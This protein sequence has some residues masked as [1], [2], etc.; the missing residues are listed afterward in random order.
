MMSTATAVSDAGD[1]RRADALYRAQ[2]SL[3]HHRTDRLF[4]ALMAIQWFAGIAA[5]LWISPR[6]WS[7]AISEPHLHVWAAILLG[8]AITAL[9]VL[10]AWQRPGSVVTRHVIAIGQMLTSALLIHLTGGRIETHFHIFGS[11]AFLACY[12]DW[13]VLCTAT[14]VVAADHGLRGWLWPESVY[15]VIAGAPLRLIEHAGW[16]VF[17]D[18]F[19]IVTIRQS[20]ADMR[21]NADHQAQLESTNTRIEAEVARRTEELRQAMDDTARA[22]RQ[23]IEANKV[24]EEQNKE[25][26]QFTYVA[27]HDLQE[28]VRKLVSFSRLLEQDI[29]GDLNEDAK[30]DLQ[31]IVDA[32][33]RMRTLVQALLELS[34]VGRSAMK[35]DPVDLNH[36]VDDAL[37]ALELKIDETGAVIK[38]DRFP[39]VIGDQTM[40]TQLLQNLISNALKFTEEAAPEIRL[41]ATGDEDHWTLGVRDNGIGMKSEYAERIFQPFQRLHNRGEYEGTGIG[42]SICKKTVQRH[43]GQIWV[44]SDI[45]RGAHFR[46]T[47][48]VA[49]IDPPG[50]DRNEGDSAVELELATC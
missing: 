23:L 42:L 3:I 43:S 44:E 8:G 12:R 15:G 47:L 28:P 45:G 18:L 1:R 20:L 49:D 33:K 10:L 31:F 39:V 25:L 38:R 24:L 9:P 11:L 29:D 50:S 16:V 30:R 26:D 41:T 46:F 34:R 4:A 22:S 36:C 6:T 32:A 19:L 5:A 14:I 2:Q 13:R 27:S 48:P 17:E 35:H 40:L 7:G 37:E 21:R